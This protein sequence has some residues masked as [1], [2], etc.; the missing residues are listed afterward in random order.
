VQ[1]FCHFKKNDILAPNLKLIVQYIFCIPGTSAPVE[2]IFSLMNNAWLDERGSMDEN[3]VRGLM[4]CNM[5]F[6]LTCNKLY[7]KI[8]NNLPVLK[9]IHSTEKYQN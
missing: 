3:T 9:K 6:G 2:R 4:V 7:E 8:K 5:K 1:L